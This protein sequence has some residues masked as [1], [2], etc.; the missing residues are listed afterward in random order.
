MKTRYLLLREV[1]DPLQSVS[2]GRHSACH[3]LHVTCHIRPLLPQDY[4]VSGQ[5]LNATG[6]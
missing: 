5:A 2:L 6:S 1:N 3:H 4:H